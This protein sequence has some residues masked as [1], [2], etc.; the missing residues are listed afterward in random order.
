VP[1]E[2]GHD[3]T[4]GAGDP[5]IVDAGPLRASA[6]RRFGD[7]DL[8]Q[9]TRP[10]VGDRGVLRHRRSPCE[11]AANAIAESARAKMNPPWQMP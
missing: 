5:D 1:A 7:Q 8:I 6:L 2:F 4:V 3:F 10:Q 11:L 9:P